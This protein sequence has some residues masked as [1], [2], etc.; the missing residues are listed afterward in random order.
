MPVKFHKITIN[1]LQT[2]HIIQNA[3]SYAYLHLYYQQTSLQIHNGTNI[4]NQLY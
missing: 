1:I 3:L 2:Y 4:K